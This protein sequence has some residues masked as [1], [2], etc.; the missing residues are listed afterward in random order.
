MRLLGLEDLHVYRESL[1]KVQLRYSSRHLC[2]DDL[3]LLGW[4]QVRFRRLFLVFGHVLVHL[5]PLTELFHVVLQL[6]V[7]PLQLLHLVDIV[8][9]PA[10]PTT[11]GRRL[12]FLGSAFIS[13]APAVYPL[14]DAEGSHLALQGPHLVVEVL[15]LQLQL[16][17]DVA[18]L[19]R[20][21]R[22]RLEGYPL[23][24]L[25][26]LLVKQGDQ[27]AK[28]RFTLGGDVRAYLL[29]DAVQEFQSEGLDLQADL[30]VSEEPDVLIGIARAAP[31]YLDGV[32]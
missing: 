21:H 25:R 19:V 5:K 26:A 29:R 28:S 12:V 9:V 16:P 30:D 31:P 18:G 20:H 1:L 3:N 24:E 32:L 6:V 2:F 15:I 22:G 4:P 10:F 7:P 17:D 13:V 23:R 11:G 8:C 27:V 14:A